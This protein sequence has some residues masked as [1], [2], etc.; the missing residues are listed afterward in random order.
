[1][2]VPLSSDLSV[3]IIEGDYRTEPQRKTE[4]EAHKQRVDL[5]KAKWQW[6]KIRGYP[7][8]RYTP[9]DPDLVGHKPTAFEHYKE[10]CRL[11]NHGV[12]L[13]DWNSWLALNPYYI[14]DLGKDSDQ[15]I[16][17]NLR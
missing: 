17:K 8:G 2:S 10:Y 14:Y 16:T 11:V 1:M 4:Y 13:P 15:Y 7:Y 5:W 3:E 12:D 9:R 6:K